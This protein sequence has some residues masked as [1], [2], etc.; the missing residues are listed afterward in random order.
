MISSTTIQDIP[1]DILHQ[2]VSIDEPTY[3]N[4]TIALPDFGRTINGK[5]T[6]QYKAHFGHVVHHNATIMIKYDTY[7]KN[8]KR[9]RRNVVYDNATLHMR[10]KYLHN[11]SGPALVIGEERYK[12]PYVRGWYVDGEAKP[13]AISHM[14]LRKGQFTNKSDT[15]DVIVP[16]KMKSIDGGSISIADY[17]T[18]LL[19][20]TDGYLGKHGILTSDTR[21]VACSIL[22]NEIDSRQMSD[23][24]N[25]EVK[26]AEKTVSIDI[27]YN[28]HY[29]GV[30]K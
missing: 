30:G 25:R 26:W 28:G 27:K 21:F 20:V 29:I 17:G 23:I 22:I 1:F 7:D 12:F 16:L 9:T 10:G 8:D 5:M 4:L 6:E 3:Y 2:I 24:M 14:E 11:L 13:G 19:T 15:G 18:Y